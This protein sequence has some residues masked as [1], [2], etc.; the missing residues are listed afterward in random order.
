ME[1]SIS[2]V[3]DGD[4]NDIGIVF[5]G[6]NA[7]RL[8]TL[9]CGADISSKLKEISVKRKAHNIN[10]SSLSLIYNEIGEWSVDGLDDPEHDIIYDIANIANEYNGS[11]SEV[12][13]DIEYATNEGIKIEVLFNFI[14][15]LDSEVKK[16][17]EKLSQRRKLSR[18][19]FHF[20]ENSIIIPTAVGNLTIDDVMLES[21]IEQ[22]KALFEK[23]FEQYVQASHDEF[24][25]RYKQINDMLNA[26]NELSGFEQGE[27]GE[28]GEQAINDMV[29]IFSQIQ[30]AY[31]FR[32]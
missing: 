32:N 2:L 24:L 7:E 13:R 8:I 27:Q 12:K 30:K 5:G 6:E 23:N 22:V 25:P 14:K 28:Q 17:I 15:H 10:V 18:V 26:V 9:A 11:E 21:L 19:L 31:P 1:F 4:H 20:S 29:L 16:R 3:S